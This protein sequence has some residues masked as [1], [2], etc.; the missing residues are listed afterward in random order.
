MIRNNYCFNERVVSFETVK[1]IVAAI[2][3]ENNA[4]AKKFKL[5]VSERANLFS[6]E[7]NDKKVDEF[8][9]PQYTAD[10]RKFVSI[11]DN[12]IFR[13]GVSEN[14]YVEYMTILT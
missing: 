14:D 9:E 7:W 10:C 11:I 2:K 8:T 12:A 4:L 5:K 6:I 13:A 3:Q 1:S